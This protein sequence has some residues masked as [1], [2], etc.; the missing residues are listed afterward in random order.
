MADAGDGAPRPRVT[1]IGEAL[2]DLV[3]LADPGSYRA[4]PGGSGFNVAIALARLGHRTAP[5][6]RFADN[7]FGN[8]LRSH[9][10]AAGLD[11]GYA[12][13]ATEP[14]TLAVVS[15]DR[16]GRASY[17]FYMEGTADWQWSDA[18]LARLPADT[19]VLHTGSLAAWTSPGSEVIHAATVRL[20]QDDR[21]LISYDPNVRPATLRKPATARQRIEPSVSVAHV[22]KASGEDVEWLYPDTP[23]DQVAKRWLDLGALLVV[24]T[25]GPDGAHFFSPALPPTHRPGRRIR[26]ADTIGAGDA[27]TAGLL[28]GLA[29]RGVCT[30]GSLRRC[31]PDLVADVVDEAVLVSALT[32]ERV[33]ADPPY[34]AG[35]T[36]SAPL[37]PLTPADLS[38]R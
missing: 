21:T 6:A 3:P 34:A 29:R 14:T 38:F 20:H 24:I 18:E 27:F 4:R 8:L 35:S 7:G 23:R 28:G 26:L 12:P 33:G 1:V 25:D 32:C 31:P 36:W 37:A 30:P 19:A 17:D 11:L 9:A 16:D 10:E 22:V 15:L 5:M 2:I 13:L